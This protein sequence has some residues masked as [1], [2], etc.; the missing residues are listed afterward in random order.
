MGTVPPAC[1]SIAAEPTWVFCASRILRVLSRRPTVNT[2]S[3]RGLAVTPLEGMGGWL[4]YLVPAL[5]LSVLL[6]YV[7]A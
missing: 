1:R 3:E 7:N 6:G 4:K 2:T 5:F